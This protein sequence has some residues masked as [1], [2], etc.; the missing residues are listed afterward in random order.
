MSQQTLTRP[1]GQHLAFEE[2]GS[3]DLVLLLPGIGDL[4]SEYRFLTP[5]LLEAGYRVVSADLRG[6]GDSSGGFRE[7]T[8]AAVAGDILALIDH[9]GGPATVIGTSFAP[10]AASWAA[11][12]APAKI[13]SLVLISPHM[14]DANTGFAAVAMKL[15]LGALLS[16]PWKARAWEGQYASWY[17]SRKPDDFDG[18]R[19]QIRAMAADPERAR[20]IRQLLTASRDGLAERLERVT[21]PALVIMGAKDS[22]FGDPE[23]EGRKVA[24]QLGA[25]LELVAGAGHYPQAEMP[26]ETAHAILAFLARAAAPASAAG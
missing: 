23:G 6:H 14:E 26:A 13:R 7:Y 19:R 22:H 16:G 2:Q 1:D 20:A 9:L 8:V 15:V 25:E 12:E 11:A 4:R 18:H 3:G 21:A 5:A 17:P 10:A 24:E